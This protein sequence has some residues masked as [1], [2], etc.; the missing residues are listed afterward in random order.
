M[1]ILWI[2]YFCFCRTQ[3]QTKVKKSENGKVKQP[4]NQTTVAYI[5]HVLRGF[6]SIEYGQQTVKPSNKNHETVLKTI[7]K[8]NFQPTNSNEKWEKLKEAKII[9]C[10]INLMKL[11]FSFVR[12]SGLSLKSKS[13]HFQQRHR[14]PKTEEAQIHFATFL[15]VHLISSLTSSRICGTPVVIRFNLQV[16]ADFD[17]LWVL[18][19]FKSWFDLQHFFFYLPVCSFFIQTMR[20]RWHPS[21]NRM[22]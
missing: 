3:F 17:K 6:M 20:V 11:L 15:F 22:L 18:D 4:N 1:D 19:D 7:N 10:A 14:K 5:V 12:S 9:K 21:S 13:V 8:F 16:L 2:I